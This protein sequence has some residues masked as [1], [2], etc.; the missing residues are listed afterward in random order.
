MLA[1]QITDLDPISLRVLISDLRGLPLSPCARFHCL[2]AGADLF[3]RRCILRECLNTA[4]KA[5][6][7]QI[8]PLAAVNANAGFAIRHVRPDCFE[9]IRRSGANCAYS[10]RQLMDV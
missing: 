7:V 9:R 10:G 2:A 3:G 8:A 5:I 4:S 1:L 6:L